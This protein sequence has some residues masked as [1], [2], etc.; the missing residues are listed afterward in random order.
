MKHPLKNCAKSIIFSLWASAALGAETVAPGMMAASESLVK[1]ISQSG[2]LVASILAILIAI[3]VATWA[4]AAAKFIYL[5]KLE[6][7]SDEFVSEF[8]KATSLDHFNRNIAD[9]SYSPPREVFRGSYR[10]F[11]R[12]RSRLG[13]RG[14]DYSAVGF[15][16]DNVS[17]AM[18]KARLN[19]RQS[20]ER[21]LSLLAISASVSPF[22]GLFGTVWGIIGAFEGIARS[23]SASLAAVAPGIS[24]ALV[25]TAF[26]LA[27]AIPA[28]IGYNLANNKIR[29]ILT[30]IDSFGADFLNMVE[31]QVVNSQDGDQ[32]TNKARG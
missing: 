1:P 17:R 18:E 29:K 6:N 4:I 30:N 15:V 8:S 2:L 21:F 5:R 26:G 19:E 20:M 10:E 25:A 28:A 14:N 13:A 24:E 7:L 32:A 23:G 16:L 12:G 11:S 22:I 27:A 3:S 31:G 9:F